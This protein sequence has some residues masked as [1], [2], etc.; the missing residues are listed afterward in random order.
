M[1]EGLAIKC[2][3]LIT[4]FDG[5]LTKSKAEDRIKQRVLAHTRTSLRHFVEVARERIYI[6]DR[7]VT[8]FRYGYLRD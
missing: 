6:A 3:N 4:S 2:F 7:H 8:L 5:N 1:N